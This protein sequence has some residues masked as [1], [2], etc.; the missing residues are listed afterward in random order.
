M[1]SYIALVTIGIMSLFYSVFTSTFAELH[2]TFSFL[3]F[4]VFIGEILLF[5]CVVLLCFKKEE[6]IAISWGWRCALVVYIIF[7]LIKTFHGYLTLGPLA[8]RTAALFY[9]PLFAVFGYVFYHRALFN[10]PVMIIMTVVFLAG[11]MFR[12][13]NPYFFVSYLL[14]F[15][16]VLINMER[17]KFIIPKIICVIL[18]LIHSHYLFF[19]GSRSHV[20]ASVG[21]FIFLLC[22]I[23]SIHRLAGKYKLMII[24]A[25]AMGFFAVLNQH[26][27]KNSIE[28]LMNPRHVIQQYRKYDAVI[29]S[30]KI[31]FQSQVI[32]PRIFNKDYMKMSKKIA[33]RLDLYKEDSASN[34]TAELLLIEGNAVEDITSEDEGNIKLHT[35]AQQDGMTT[36]ITEAHLEGRNLDVAYVNILFR[37]FIWR[38][39]IEEF[40][41]M[42]PLWGI[43]FG[44][45][46]RSSSLEVLCWA[47]TEWERDG[48]ITPHNSSLHV[49]YRAGIWGGIFIF[50]FF[51]FFVVMMR[52]LIRLRSLTGGILLSVFVYWIILANFLVILE[53]PHY[54]IPFWTLLG[55]TGAYRNTLLKR[56]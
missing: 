47:E 51:T 52:D 43:N 30:K 38:D 34:K 4:P 37:L 17:G 55:L 35:E 32:E 40:I 15:W 53:F 16:A 36:Q 27:D 20:L 10:K 18:S 8:C 1:I 23:F 12:Y 48:W 31:N 25:A 11:V 6:L 41:V 22:F 50:G 9:Y 3:P 7:L 21:V 14:L 46:Q 29:Q 56:A 49:I 26:A 39:M 54:A 13:F 19:V 28:S 5:L 45:P 33:R 2:I 24:I 42:K 44:K